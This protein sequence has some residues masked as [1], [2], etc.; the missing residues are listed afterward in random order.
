MTDR[1]YYNTAGKSYIEDVRTFYNKP[2]YPIDDPNEA[3]SLPPTGQLG[4][5]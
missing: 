3:I 1:E 5:S 2:H 4:K